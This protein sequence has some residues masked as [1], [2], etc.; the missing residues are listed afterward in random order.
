MPKILLAQITPVLHD[1]KA[2][3]ILFETYMK[4]AS[5]K[6]ADLILFPELSLTGY[7][8][9]DKTVE[10]A[11]SI[12]DG[13]SIKQICQWAKKYQLKTVFGFPE[14]KDGNVYNSACM[15]DS[16]GSVIGAYQKVHLWDEEGK[17]FS[18]GENYYVWETDIGKI[19]DDLL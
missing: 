6:G 8:T 3:L 1:K 14:K 18:A 13:K 9:R 17:Y 16:D 10:L 15:V 12:E 2:N 4:E 11:E 7:F 19:V 5:E